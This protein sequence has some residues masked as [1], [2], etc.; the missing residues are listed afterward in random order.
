MD[1]YVYAACEEIDAAFFS[2]DAFHN[3]ERLAEIEH[4]LGRWSREAENIRKLLAEELD[5][6]KKP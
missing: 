2:S 4:Y 3:P 5:K 6:S 1:E